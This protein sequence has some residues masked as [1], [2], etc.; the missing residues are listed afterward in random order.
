MAQ[1]FEWKKA[2][3]DH[4]VFV[5]FDVFFLNLWSFSGNLESYACQGTHICCALGAGRQHCYWGPNLIF[6]LFWSST[7]NHWLLGRSA[8]PKK[9]LESRK[10]MLLQRVYGIIHVKRGLAQKTLPMSGCKERRM[11]TWA[12]GDVGENRDI[13]V[14]SQ[15]IP[16]SQF[17]FLQKLLH[18]DHLRWYL[19]CDGDSGGGEESRGQEPQDRF[20]FLLIQQECFY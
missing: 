5:N 9:L 19:Q 6:S 1:F 18:E 7:F 15:D 20:W 4:C 11:D 17:Q 2:S 16:N 12:G 8:F 14:S 10:K 3:L 13:T